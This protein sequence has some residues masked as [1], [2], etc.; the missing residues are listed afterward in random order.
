MCELVARKARS[1]KGILPPFSQLRGHVSQPADFDPFWSASGISMQ[2][3]AL[4]GAPALNSISLP[5]SASPLP[6]VKVM[7]CSWLWPQ[8][9]R[10][11]PAS[12]PASRPGRRAGLRA[13][14]FSIHSSTV[15]LANSEANCPGTPGLEDGGAALTARWRPPPRSLTDCY[16]GS[17]CLNTNEFKKKRTGGARENKSNIKKQ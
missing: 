2:K 10:V 7:D 17:A 6:Q 5:R 13:L 14:L 9:C 16:P 8:S 3:R 12:R 11:T 15:T 4:K 1:R